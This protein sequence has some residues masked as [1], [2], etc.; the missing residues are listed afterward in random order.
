MSLCSWIPSDGREMAPCCCPHRLALCSGR[1]F[2]RQGSQVPR[3]R[4]HDF[5][6]IFSA[7]ILLVLFLF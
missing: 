1:P 7:W 6:F 5:M 3:E 2:S 4:Q